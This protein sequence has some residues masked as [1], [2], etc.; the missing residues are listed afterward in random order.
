VAGAGADF[1]QHLFGL[2]LRNSPIFARTDGQFSSNIL[3][4]CILRFARQMALFRGPGTQILHE[5]CTDFA[6]TISARRPAPIFN[7]PACRQGTGGPQAF[8]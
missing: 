6:C 5:F 8:E 3:L 1:I 2:F 4:D 7:D